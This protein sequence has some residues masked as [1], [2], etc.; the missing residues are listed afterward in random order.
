M[1]VYWLRTYTRSNRLVQG[2]MVG[3]FNL[4]IKRVT[5]VT[6]K[7]GSVVRGTFSKAVNTFRGSFTVGAALAV[8]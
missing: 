8:A 7:V 5:T 2:M 6:N 1:G 3:P 4:S